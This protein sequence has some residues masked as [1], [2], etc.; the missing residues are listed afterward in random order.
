MECGA[1]ARGNDPNTCDTRCAEHDV[2]RRGLLITTG[3]LTG[4]AVA[5]LGVGVTFMLKEPRDPKADAVRPRL[6][7]TIRA[8]IEAAA[9]QRGLVSRIDGVRVGLWPPLRLTGVALQIRGNWRLSA[10][11]VELWWR[12]R[13]QIA[14]RQAVF[15]GPAGLT[16]D[17]PDVSLSGVNT[18]TGPTTVIAGSLAVHGR[19]AANPVVLTGGRLVG[20]TFW[21][22]VTP[23]GPGVA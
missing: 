9:A 16:I 18:Y 20:G 2:R 10:D 17:G 13:T 23:A 22:D 7:R 14:V 3:V 8:R 5:G 19:Q 6:E 21:N 1:A 11:A 12:G 4:I 15:H